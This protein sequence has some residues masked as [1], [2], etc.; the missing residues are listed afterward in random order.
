[1]KEVTFKM[2]L[3]G[4][5]RISFGREDLR[6][7]L[8]RTIRPQCMGLINMTGERWDTSSDSQSRDYKM[9]E[10]GWW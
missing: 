4:E 10:P 7:A 5:V 8:G 6:D 2:D 9:C 1:M 3:K